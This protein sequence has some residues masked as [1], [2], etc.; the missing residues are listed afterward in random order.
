MIKG[1]ATLSLT[2]QFSDVHMINISL[3]KL[4]VDSVT[5]KSKDIP[6]IYNDTTITLAFPGKLTPKDTFNLN[7]Y[8]HGQPVVEPYGWGGFHFSGDSLAYNLGIALKDNPPNYGRTWFPCIDNFTDRASYDFY[9]KVLDPLIAV[10][11]GLLT[12]IL[13]QGNGTTLYHWKLEEKIPAYLASVAVSDYIA[14]VDTFHGINGA[15]PTYIYVNP[16]DSIK[17]VKSF[18][19]LNATLATFED[20]FGPYR[21]PRVGYVST[22]LGAMEHATN[23]AYPES[24]IDGTLKSEHIFAHELS[25]M[26]FGDLVTCHSAAEMWINEGWASFCE[27]IFMEGIYGASAAKEYM[28]SK[29]HD[30]LKLTHHTDGGYY[31]LSGIPP[32]LTYGS[33]VY[34]KG[35]MVVSTLRGYIG[36]DLFFKTVK[37]YLNSFAFRDVNSMQM[38]DFFSTGSGIKLDD[39]FETWV[40]NPGFPH[41]SIDSVTIGTDGPPYAVTVYIRQKMKGTTHISNSNKLEIGFGREDGYIEYGNITFSGLRGS[42]TFQLPFKPAWTG[43]D[44][45]EKTADATTDNYK[46]IKAPGTVDFPQTYCTVEAIEVPETTMVRVIHNWVA[47]D[48]LPQPVP[49]LTLS[50]SRY[51]TIEGMFPPGFKARG[52]FS[53]SKFEFLDYDIITNATDSLILLYRPSSAFTWQPVNFRQEGGKFEGELIIDS[54]MK[55]EYTL[56]VWN[57]DSLNIRK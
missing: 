30:V 22:P 1:E 52:K 19:N 34:D 31:A 43:L 2:S 10:C 39:F 46:F 25:H 21:W 4:H 48:P 3:Y 7:I 16:T 36:D 8:Y 53:Y 24:S 5:Y 26:W 11:D 32:N 15:I 42:R 47:P 41:F 55:G 29:F 27:G 23:I 40:F 13:L 45:N 18:I 54:L 57:P 51:W 20:H 49:G 6:F 56:G 35:A 37:D 50:T 44:P 33:T 14:L 9:I 17:A 12:E 28:R 38:R